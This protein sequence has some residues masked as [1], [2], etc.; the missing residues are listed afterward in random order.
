VKW[1]RDVYDRLAET[2]FDAAIMDELREAVTALE[3]LD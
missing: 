1:Y 2:G 3:S